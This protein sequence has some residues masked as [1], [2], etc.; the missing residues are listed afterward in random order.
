MHFDIVN[1]WEFGFRVNFGNPW[2][3]GGFVLSLGRLM[4][5]AGYYD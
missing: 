1:G 2:Q 4:I 5:W 3:T